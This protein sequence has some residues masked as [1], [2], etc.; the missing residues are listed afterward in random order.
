MRL[1]HIFLRHLIKQEHTGS[2]LLA[3]AQQP[4]RGIQRLGSPLTYERGHKIHP[5]CLAG[6]HGHGAHRG[7]LQ[8]LGSCNSI[9]AQR[10]QAICIAQQQRAGWRGLRRHALC[11]DQELHVELL[12]QLAD[13]NGHIVLYSCTG[14]CQGTADEA[15]ADQDEG[16]AEAHRDIH[17]CLN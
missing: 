14:G 11:A 15:G 3:P 7:V 5:R 2:R 6:S 1:L 13:Q 17:V 16:K 4:A 9:A 10:E 12:L 8:V